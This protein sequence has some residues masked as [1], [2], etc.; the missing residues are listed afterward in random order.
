MSNPQINLTV[1]LRRQLRFIETS[2][3][4]YDQ[5]VFDEAVR[6]AVALRVLFHDT[7]KSTSLLT[8]MGKKATIQLLSTAKKIH[9]NQLIDID[10]AFFMP[11]TFTNNGISHGIQDGTVMKNMPCDDWWNEPVFFQGAVLSRKDV[12]LC[13]AN[14]DGGAHVD[15]KPNQKTTSLRESWGTVTKKSGGVIATEDITN[16]HFPMLRQFGYETLNSSDLSDLI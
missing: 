7:S 12:V 3:R 1:Q 5:G 2:C 13:S 4:A 11:I 14:Q 16:H 15:I 6:I 8:H 10:I 9:P